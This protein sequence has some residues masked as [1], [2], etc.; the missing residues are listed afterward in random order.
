MFSTDIYFPSMWE[1]K[2]KGKVCP[3]LLGANRGTIWLGSCLPEHIDNVFNP[4][5]NPSPSYTGSPD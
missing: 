4:W 3:R 5:S 2:K 1:V